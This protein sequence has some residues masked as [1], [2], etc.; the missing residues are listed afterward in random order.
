M[1]SSD[2]AKIVL[3]AATDRHHNGIAHE[4]CIRDIFKTRQ[5]WRILAVRGSKYFTPASP[6]G[7]RSAHRF[8]W[9]CA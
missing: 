7:N 4:L 1:A 9:P 6:P 5:N 8:A 2:T 3:V